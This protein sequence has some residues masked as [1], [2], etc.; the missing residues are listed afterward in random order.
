M[1]PLV[2]EWTVDGPRDRIRAT[3]R[4]ESGETVELAYGKVVASARAV[5]DANLGSMFSDNATYFPG[6]LPV[7]HTANPSLRSLYWRGAL[8]VRYQRRDNPASVLGRT[9]Y[10][11]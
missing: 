9:Y 4:V 6:R 1:H 8:G 7:L 10:T 3:C 11:S 5:G 2:G